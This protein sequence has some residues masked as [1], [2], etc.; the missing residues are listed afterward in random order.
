MRRLEDKFV[1]KM[2]LFCMM[3]GACIL[4]YIIYIY[5]YMRILPEGIIFFAS[6]VAAV[7]I[8]IMLGIFI[9]LKLRHIFD[10]FT[11][12][13]I[14]LIVA[15]V[16][17]LF[18]VFGPVFIDRSI[19]YHIVFYAARNGKVNM[20]EI[21]DTFSKEIFLKRIHDAQEAGFIVS[22]DEGEFTP[23]LKAK[24]FTNIMYNLGK[25]T[26]CLNTYEDM[27]KEIGND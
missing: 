23:T 6:C 14:S 5:I 11:S 18:S 22:E 1:K 13:V 2:L 7:I 16:L 25:A 15:F 10:T 27:E 4:I 20:Q 21:E 19:S 26:N 3:L 8:A 17:L 12:V 24:I 9:N